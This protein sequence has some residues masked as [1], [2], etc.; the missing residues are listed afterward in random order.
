MVV[1]SIV[2]SVS[3]IIPVYNEEPAIRELLRRVFKAAL[4]DGIKRDVYVVDDGS[5]D[6]TVGHIDEF[7]TEYPQYKDSLHIFKSLVNHGKGAAVRAGF[8]L[9]KGDVIIIQ[10]GDL[11]YSP[12]DYPALLEPFKNPEVDVVYGS[13][14]LR[15]TPKGMRKLNLLANLIL[16]TTTK[17][18][19]KT[20]LTD[21]ATG[22][23]VFRRSILDSITFKSRGFEFCPEFTSKVLSAGYTI[24]E[25][26]IRYNARGILEGKK[27]KARDGFIAVWWLI[28]LRFAATSKKTE[29]KAKNKESRA[30]T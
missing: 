11:E 21:E 15:G 28:K 30:L 20:K 3:I 5:T 23:K 26:P 29:E 17:L 27:I 4:P 25:V 16:T 7:L 14:F 1:D 12:D 18:L 10:D 19:Y 6:S 22:Y 9:A 24:V 8:K 2:K 13:R